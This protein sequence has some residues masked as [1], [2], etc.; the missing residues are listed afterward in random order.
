MIS[1]SPQRPIFQGNTF[2]KTPCQERRAETPSKGQTVEWRN[3][4]EGQKG[5]RPPKSQTITKQISPSQSSWPNEDQEQIVDQEKLDIIH[6]STSQS[7]W[8]NEDGERKLLSLKT[9]AAIV[10]QKDAQEPL[11][12][13]YIT[14]M[15]G[16][17][18]RSIKRPDLNFPRK[19]LH[20]WPSAENPSPKDKSLYGGRRARTNKGHA[21]EK[22]DHIT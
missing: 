6:I 13:K 14:S 12:N 1:R 20:K 3:K 11:K 19:H 7:P 4:G 15:V 8:P 10:R 16:P 5:N 9:M 21:A 2:P 22:L 17:T 18:Q